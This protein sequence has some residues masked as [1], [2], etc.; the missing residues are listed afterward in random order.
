MAKSKSMTIT[1]AVFK[2]NQ[3]VTLVQSTPKEHVKERVGR[4][5]R[6]FRYVTGSYIISRL[7]TVF[8]WGWSFEVANSGSSPSG[9]SVWVQG[10]LTILDPV[11]KQPMI[12]KEQ[13][14]SSEYKMQ[15]DGKEVDYADDLKAA[16]TD[17]LK[18]C[19]SLLG[20]SAD[21][22]ADE[23]TSNEITE[24][25]EQVKQVI[26]EMKRKQEEAKEVK[27]VKEVKEENATVDN[28]K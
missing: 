5:N 27:I 22:Y 18:K 15:K 12:V 9:D 26:I 7:N 14:G 2:Q 6:R 24:R 13:F 23:T 4:G 8:G 21:V 19:A 17:A 28:S 1:E 25:A 16:S 10:R 20:L 3:L 11:S